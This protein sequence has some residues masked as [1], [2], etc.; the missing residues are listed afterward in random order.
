MHRRIASTFFFFFLIVSCATPEKQAGVP[1]GYQP[2]S[3]L[4]T[5]TVQETGPEVSLLTDLFFGVGPRPGDFDRLLTAALVRYPGN[6]ELHEMAAWWALVQGDRRTANEHLMRAACDLSSPHTEIYLD[7]LNTSLSAGEKRRLIPL[8][9]IL[10]EKH[11]D[12]ALRAVARALQADLLLDLGRLDEARG[13]ANRLHYLADWM[14]IGTFDNDQGKGFYEIYPPEQEIDFTKRYKG[15][16]G[17]IGWMG[18]V[19][20]RHDRFLSLKNLFHPD[21]WSVAYLVTHVKSPQETEALLSVS[22]GN[23]TALWL[24]GVPIYANDKLERFF[25]DTIRVPIRLAKGWNRILV[26]SAVENNTWLFAARLTAPDGT[27]LENVVIARD[28]R[29]EPLAV[30]VAQPAVRGETEAE[31]LLPTVTEQNRLF[32]LQALWAER[33][34]LKKKAKQAFL[35]FYEGNPHNP[36]A[37]YFAAKSFKENEEEGQLIDLLNRALGPEGIKTAGFLIQRGDFYR[38]KGIRDSAEEDY[39]AALALNQKAKGAWWGLADI[40][41]DRG[42]AKDRCD[43]F[44]AMTRLWPDD[45]DIIKAEGECLDALGYPTDAE[46]RFRAALAV[47]PGRLAFVRRLLTEARDRQD[48]A[49]AITLLDI[50]A[51][52]GPDNPDYLIERAEMLRR[53][54]RWDEAKRSL[55]RAAALSPYDPRP[56]QNLGDLAWERGMH[57]E[58]LRRWNEALARNP[59][60]AALSDKIS[61][62]S[63][64]AEKDPA[65]A[66]VP[67][68]D[69]IRTLIEAARAITPDPAAK[70]L[71]VY[72]HAVVKVND[73]GSSKWYITEVKLVINDAGR[74]ILINESLP[75]TG[76]VKIRKAY[77]LDPKGVRQE[78]SSIRGSQVRFRQLDKGSATVVQYIHYSPALR[79]LENHFLAEW[80]LQTTYYQML[81]S[82]LR[83]I[84]DP[85]R[86]LVFDINGVVEEKSETLGDKVMKI[87]IAKNRPPLS[88]EPMMPP[89]GDFLEKITI[90]SVSSW[91]EYV[92]WERALLKNAFVS[93]KEVRD[94]AVQLTEGKGT[95]HEKLDALFRFVAQEIRYQQ[96]YETTIAGVKPHTPTQI[97]ERR[98]GDCKDKAVLMIQLAKEIGIKLEYA[99]L[100]TRPTGKLQMKI[101][102]QQFNHA[103]VHVP[104]QPGIEENFFMDP[105]VDLL[106]IGTLRADD[107]GVISLVM[108]T[109]TAAW[110]FIEIPYQPPAFTFE[111]HDLSFTVGDDGKTTVK[112]RLT[113]RGETSSTIR[114]ILR[115]QRDADKLFQ[116]V[117]NSLFQGGTLVR[118]EHSDIEDIT[119][120]LVL[121]VEADVSHLLAAQEGGKRLRIP[122]SL[123]R[124]DTVKM[125]TRLL[126]MELGIKGYMTVSVRVELPPKAKV[127][128]PPQSFKTVGP[129]FTVERTVHS[130]GNIVAMQTRYTKECTVLAPADYPAFRTAAQ[131]VVGRQEEHLM[132]K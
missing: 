131:E 16:N 1:S 129:C 93:N 33:N 20:L 116:G 91:D 126:P 90:S 45:A 107:Q 128:L 42:L 30:P 117:V 108:D 86:K 4:C 80:Y 106:E 85:K 28:T 89:V 12:L 46:T 103:I 65:E 37:M 32:F 81:H 8:V 38:Q 2:E 125:S 9:G 99:I 84:Y 53:L 24:N 112:A 14:V 44:A 115:T 101:P 49:G 76:T 83:I 110:R 55:E 88:P 51:L 132:F 121:A 6:H 75:Y 66:F 17:E 36:I 31:T 64:T 72:D 109:D 96:D 74:D 98:Y 97:L 58:A 3:P 50:M 95:P 62:L 94:L 113:M 100:R 39:R 40:L 124:A 122:L 41:G 7:Q 70:A 5:A 102:N 67:S 34:G 68:D 69:D 22:T 52:L 54:K 119:R 23:P 35:S 118:A 15:Q 78:A 21:N 27:P 82:E 25:Y 18:V 19:P 105:T 11:P 77:S 57:D 114:R 13:I 26:K 123:I 10:A 63:A 59:K 104:V 73:D 130:T 61:Y 43:T 60:N 47:E 92:N 127:T 79:F 71:M 56:Y 29:G 87:F 120:P 48:Y 111:E